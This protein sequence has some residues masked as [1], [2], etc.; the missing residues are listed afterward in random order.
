MTY[1]KPLPRIDNVL[2]LRKLARP[3]PAT[4]GKILGIAKAWNFSAGTTDFLK[5]FP[6]DEVFDSGDDFLTRCDELELLIREE[7]RMPVESLRS[8]QD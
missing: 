6:E 7:R 5:L 4:A 8:P 2:W 3:F 1:A